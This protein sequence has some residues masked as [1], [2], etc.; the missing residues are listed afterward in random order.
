MRLGKPTGTP[1]KPQSR[2]HTDGVQSGYSI[3]AIMRNSESRSVPFLVP[4]E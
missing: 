2:R 1:G 4:P 3:C